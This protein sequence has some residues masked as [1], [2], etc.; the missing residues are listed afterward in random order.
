MTTPPLLSELAD[1]KVDYTDPDDPVLIRPDGSPIDTWRE[2]YPYA[3]RMERKEY[4]WHKR[5]QQIELRKLQNWVKA[6]GRRLV[7]VF[8]GRDA[9]G[10]GGT[11]KRF[12]EHLNPRGARVVA[13]EKPTER[14]SGQWYFQRCVGH[15]PTASE[16]SCVD[17]ALSAG[18]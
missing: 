9:A 2:N 16:A 4:E 12:T 15:L 14:E 3:H 8:E 5:L 13:L 6:T 10:K 11:I 18:S 7:V 1:L 17:S